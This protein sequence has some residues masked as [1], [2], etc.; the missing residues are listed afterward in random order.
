MLSVFSIP[1]T[2]LASRCVNLGYCSSNKEQT[3]KELLAGCQTIVERE[4]EWG[5][6]D[7]FQHVNNVQFNRWFE[8]V[9]VKHMGD[10]SLSCNSKSYLSP[11]GVG[12]ILKDVYTLF[13]VEIKFLGLCIMN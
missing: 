6:M 4:V 2:K 12:P 9:R 13:K 8:I 5:S 7:A 3:I 10:L 1:S 11:V